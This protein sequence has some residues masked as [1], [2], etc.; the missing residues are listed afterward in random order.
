MKSLTP[1]IHLHKGSGPLNCQNFN[2]IAITINNLAIPEQE[3]RVVSRTYGF[4]QVLQERIPVPLVNQKVCFVHAFNCLNNGTSYND[5]KRVE[6][7]GTFISHNTDPNGTI[8]KHL[9]G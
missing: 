3:P 2:S 5:P 7:I 6:M 1:K 4:K 9:Q 8:T